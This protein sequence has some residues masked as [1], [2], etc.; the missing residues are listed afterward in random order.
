MRVEINRFY[1]GRRHSLDIK[2][3]FGML[4]SLPKTNAHIKYEDFSE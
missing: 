4:L 2:F 1:M 3:Y